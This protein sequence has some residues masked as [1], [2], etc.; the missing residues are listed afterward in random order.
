M[1]IF[2]YNLIGGN[3]KNTPRY[4]VLEY[5]P[6]NILYIDILYLNTA[7]HWYNN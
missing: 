2:I 5:I 3:L 7:F 1:L 4:Q 6:V